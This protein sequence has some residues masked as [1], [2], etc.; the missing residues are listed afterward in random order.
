MLVL[1]VDNGADRMMYAG[2]VLSHY[3]FRLPGLARLADS[4]WKASLQEGKLP[5]RPA[6]QQGYLV[7]KEREQSEGLQ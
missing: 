5:L 1:A 3:E 6:W 4:E 7:P 2:P